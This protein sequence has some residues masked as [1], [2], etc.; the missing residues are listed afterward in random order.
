[1]VLWSTE[2]QVWTVRERRQAQFGG[3][4]PALLTDPLAFLAAEHARQRVLQHH[5]ERL[6]SN[7]TGSRVR[8]RRCPGRVACMRAS[9]HLRDEEESLYP[10]IGTA[11][12][13][14]L[15]SLVEENHSTEALRA[16][17]RAE[18]ASNRNRPW[19]NGQLRIRGRHVRRLRIADTSISRTVTSCRSPKRSLSSTARKSITREM[20][21]R[22]AIGRQPC[23]TD[24]SHWL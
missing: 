5:L 2:G 10:R 17:L 9:M 12:C 22:R 8:H 23:L 21:A 6:A 15:A 16:S 1:M 7:R 13:P 19:A 18:L 11:G 4:D 20:A 3:L 14:A 24:P